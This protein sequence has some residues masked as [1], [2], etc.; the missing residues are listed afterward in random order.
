MA[1]PFGEE[2]RVA[3]RRLVDQGVTVPQQIAAKLGLGHVAVG[4]VVAE[5]LAEK[6]LAETAGEAAGRTFKEDEKGAELRFCTDHKIRTL[7][8]A[9]R[10]A[11]VDLA[12]WRVARWECTSWEVAMKLRETTDIGNG[13]FRIADK[14][15]KKHLWRV[16]MRLERIAPRIEV[17]AL[18]LVFAPYRAR[19]PHFGR[20]PAVPGG[21][22]VMLL[23]GLMDVHFGKLAW[24]PESGEDYDL[25]VAERVFGEA[26]ERLMG[27]TAHLK[28]ERILLPIGNDLSHIDAPD[29]TTTAG[30]IV[31]TDG[32]HAKIIATIKRS[33]LHA[34]ERL[35]RRAPVDCFGVPGNH[36]TQ[37]TTWLMH[38]I[39][40][41]FRRT[42]R[43][44]VDLSP[45]IRKYRQ[46]GRTLFGFAHGD[47]ISD[48][49][50]R[51][52]MSL[53]TAE[54]RA[55]ISETRF[56]E[57][58]CGHQHR[59]RSFEFKSTDT[60]QGTVVRFL[61]SLSATDAWHHRHGL[62]GSRRAAEVYC[63]ERED[64]YIG[65]FVAGV[66]S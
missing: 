39:D 59:S 54:Q 38:I 28:V 65:H 21:S 15:E 13:K 19:A 18:P 60:Y 27:L 22:S 36:D 58:F 26:V 24:A 25:R 63:Y 12:I 7:E 35:A 2:Q 55:V 34:I 11:E 23:V 30:T 41:Y 48:T 51:S 17:D 50:A 53:M 42:N 57:W 8:D 4:R 29:N 37:A 40:A 49:N 62:V 46:Y 64:G 61:P 56:S 45:A 3:I 47:T 1:A 43:V 44:T 16:W 5:Y 66:Q 10:Y 52:L 33:V 20:H 32:R 6:E 31:D 14:P 9:I